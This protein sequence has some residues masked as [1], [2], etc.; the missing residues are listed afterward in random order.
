MSNDIWR[1]CDRLFRAQRAGFDG[2]RH[3][4]NGCQKSEVD[5]R[6]PRA[7]FNDHMCGR[8]D[9]LSIAASIFI[10]TAINIT[11]STREREKEIECTEFH[12]KAGIRP[13]LT[14]F[15]PTRN[16]ESLSFSL[17]LLRILSISSL[18]ERSSFYICKRMH[19]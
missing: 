10:V 15:L 9:I 1:N 19:L 17:S 3:A 6:Y 11:D 7:E 12:A 4:L 16:F 2:I 13:E 8:S 5:R 14:S 18:V